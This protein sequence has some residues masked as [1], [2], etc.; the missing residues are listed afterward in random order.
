[1]DQAKKV[2]AMHPDQ[3]L[4][5]CLAGTKYYPAWPL[6]LL[7]KNGVRMPA[8]AVQ[9]RRW[10]DAESTYADTWVSGHDVLYHLADLRRKALG[11]ISEPTSTSEPVKTAIDERDPRDRHKQECPTVPSLSLADAAGTPN[12]LAGYLYVAARSSTSGTSLEQ[13]AVCPDDSTLGEGTTFGAGQGE[14]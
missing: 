5:K 3:S 12:S 14:T 11:I 9:Q 4:L 10:Q 2:F 7:K 1:V 6:V 13:A 8:P